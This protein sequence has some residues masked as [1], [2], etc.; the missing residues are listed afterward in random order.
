MINRNRFLDITQFVIDP[1]REYSKLC[2]KLNGTLINFGA[3]QSIN[4]MDIREGFLDE[5]ESYLKNKIAKLN[6]FFSMIFDG[7]SGDDKSHLEEVL[8]KCYKN[9]EITEDNDSLY[10]QDKRSA[11]LGRKTFKTC[12]MMPTIKNVYDLLKTN[13]HLKKYA[14]VLKPFISGSMSYLS[15]R[16]NVDLKSKLVVVDIHEVS[17]EQMP[18]VMFIVTDY[19]WDVIK[20]NRSEKKIL[21]LDEVWKMI[22]KNEYTA[23]FVYKLFKTIRKYGGAAT[24]ITQDISD[25]FMLE[26]GKYGKGILNN[27]SVKCIFQLEETDLNILDKAI[28]ISEEE[29][30]RIINMKR[31]TAIIHAGRNNLMIDVVSSP[32]EHQYITT[33]YVAESKYL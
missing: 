8:T 3:N 23:D 2:N 16:T 9:Y 1:D 33:D 13:K 14:N 11:I 12:D 26:D 4:I 27:S 10:M 5:G 31:G 25:F 7:L 6:I 15:N 28:Q 17:E 18:L 24:A 29:K 30:Y 22:N 20:Q 19:F 21:Y 32:K